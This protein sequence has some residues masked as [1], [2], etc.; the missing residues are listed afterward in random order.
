[1]C[2]CV[3]VF[4]CSVCANKLNIYVFLNTLTSHAKEQN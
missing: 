3:F 2:M 4:Y 1:V